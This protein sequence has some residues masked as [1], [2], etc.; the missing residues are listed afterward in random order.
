MRF[1]LILTLMIGALLGFAYPWYMYNMSGENLGKYR[2][3]ERGKGFAPADVV[4]AQSDAP[5]R[6][7]LDMAPIQGYYPDRARTML[8]L[9]ASV[10]GHTALASSLN[11]IA[12]S[13]ESK[14]LQTAQKIFRDR[15]GD[16]QTITPGTY[17]F[18]TGE[19]DIEGLSMKSVDLVLR[20]R[21]AEA[22]PRALPYGGGLVVLSVLGLIASFRRARTARAQEAAKPKW[23]RDA[24]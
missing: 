5:V 7:F 20:G 16:I 2:V 11:F 17:H 3:F 8:T 24:G 4:L 14:N 10:N 21:A 18:V 9:T 15:A 13:E 1:L 22:D 23:G 19:G 6:V 12:S